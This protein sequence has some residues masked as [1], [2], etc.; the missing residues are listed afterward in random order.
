MNAQIALLA[1]SIGIAGLFFLDQDKSNRV[2]PAV[3]LPAIWLGINGSR[4]VSSW[5]SAPGPFTGDVLAATLDG[6]PVDAAIYEVLILLGIIVL[7]KRGK[8]T[9][10]LLKAIVPVLVYF[11]Y[12]LMSTAWSPFPGPSFK[13]WIKCVGDLV[14]VLVLVTDPHP[15]A[16]LRRLFSRVGFIL[17]PLSLV[18]IRWTNLGVEYEE[19]GPHFTGVTTNKNTFGL[20]LYV[21]SIGIVWNFSALLLDKKAPNR[22]RRLIAQGAVLACNILLLQLAHSATSVFCA[23]LGSGLMLASNLPVIKKRPRRVH[24]LCCGILLAGTAGMLFGGS[25]GVASALGRSSDFSGRTE[26]WAAAIASADS[27]LVGTG[28]ESFWN[29]NAHKV[30]AILWYYN[31][32]DLSNLNSAH[33]GYLQIYLDIGWIGLSLI[34]IILFGGYLRSVKALQR[35]REL[36]GLLLAFVVTCAFYNITEAGFRIM[37]PSWF[38]LLLAVAGATAINIGLIRGEE[39]KGASSRSGALRPQPSLTEI[40]AGGRGVYS[41]QGS[42]SGLLKNGQKAWN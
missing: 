31:P 40:Y 6:N 36:G 11:L 8:K 21:L 12:C 3:W 19:D 18:L 35:N 1:C 15:V 37:T 22:T 17:L 13:R 20:I 24:I 5:F 23:A 4:P 26:I 14:M 41:V 9:G 25:G 7:A 29:K 16:A 42:T 28:F 38:S 2:S 34:L 32:G 33:D 30:R 27:P 39:Q 10:A